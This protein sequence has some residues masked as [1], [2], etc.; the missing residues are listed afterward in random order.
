[1]FLPGFPT[2]T[3]IADTTF[4][5]SVRMDE[6]GTVHYVVLEDPVNGTATKPS[7]ADLVVPEVTYPTKP[8]G[9][10]TIADASDTANG[11]VVGLVLSTSYS[12]YVLAVDN[13]VPSNNRQLDA[14]HLQVFTVE[15]TRVRREGDCMCV[16]RV[17][18]CDSCHVTSVCVCE[19]GMRG[20]ACGGAVELCGRHIVVGGVVVVVV[21]V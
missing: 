6:P 14:T 7:V 1:M 9:S 12:V 3:G 15:G 16:V 19:G 18:P 5:L 21:V 11:F 10:L 4:T 17:A 13:A 2:A 8:H 20:G